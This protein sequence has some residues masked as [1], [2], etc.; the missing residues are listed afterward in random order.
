M[1]QMTTD[2][3]V[4]E[5]ALIVMAVCMAVQTLLLLAAGVGAF[6]AW[7]RA[8][9]ALHEARTIADRQLEE[10]RVHLNRITATVEETG[11]ALQ[12]GSTAAD[13][14]MGDVR[15]AMGTVRD[16]VGSV[17]S[18]VTAPRAALALGLWRGIQMWRKRRA[19]FDH[20]TAQSSRRGTSG[21]VDV[22][23]TTET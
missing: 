19:T 18:V 23:A 21:E 11:L 3:A 17:A 8:E 14:L 7:R 1:E 6:I 10:L 4:L 9:A 16:S 15:D 13:D 12:R 2:I 20:P 5:R 22:T